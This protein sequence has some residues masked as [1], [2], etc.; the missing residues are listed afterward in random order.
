MLERIFRIKQSGSTLHTEVIAG[1]T[2]FM[3]MAY[4]IVVNPIILK[5]AGLPLRDTVTA[6]CIGAAVPTLIMGIW[7]RYP[8]AL[9]SGMGLNAALVAACLGSPPISWQTMMGVIVA[10]GIIISILVLTRV[11]EMVMDAIPMDLKRAIG[12][13]IGLFI[14]LLG[15]HNAGWMATAKGNLPVTVF[16]E[17]GF[18]TAPAL[19]AAFGLV[20]TALLFIRNVRG[21]LLYGILATTLL[22][23]VTGQTAMPTHFIS[24]PEWRT[25]GK[26]N[27]IAAIQPAMLALVFAFLL[28]DF[29]DTMG[30]VIGVG[31]QGGFL[32]SEGRL[33]RLNRVLL[34]DSLAAVWG[35]LC[36]CSS[37]TT[38]V[39]SAAGVGVGG[40][41]GL[42]GVIVA[43]LF[44]LAT[45]ISPLVEIVPAAAT[46][47]ALIVV[48]FLMMSVIKEI[49]LEDT[50]TALPAIV[51]MLVIPFTNS[52]ARGIGVGFIFYVLVQALSGRYRNVSPTLYVLAV[53]FALSFLP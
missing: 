46:A 50:A 42:V 26:L 24:R 33:P 34:V 40:R 43:T 10:E 3:T 5:A 41:T 38:Y 53:L 12:A 39:E 9:A 8:F 4:I 1:F 31:E 15:M 22:A 52:I 7:S 25:F 35:G 17:H 45:L 32:T 14:A 37:V 36:S 47:P 30:T 28:S 6:T 51:T 13:G 11:R 44:L 18:Q 29:F 49:N 19:L 48:G 21:V 23:I 16:P 2:T 20:V 27:L